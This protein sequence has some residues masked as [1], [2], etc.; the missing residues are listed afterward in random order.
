ML[1]YETEDQQQFRRVQG[2]ANGPTDWLTDW[3]DYVSL[4]ATVSFF[5]L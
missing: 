5:N 4:S 3:L 1:F 2:D